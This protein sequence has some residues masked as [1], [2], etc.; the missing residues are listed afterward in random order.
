MQGWNARALHLLQYPCAAL[1]NESLE[2]LV[3]GVDIMEMI[4][5]SLTELEMVNFAAELITFDGEYLP[6]M[7]NLVIL[8]GERKVAL[9]IKPLFGEGAARR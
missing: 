9:M 2:R 8:H 3:G 5:S 4:R 6:V 7:L 1:L